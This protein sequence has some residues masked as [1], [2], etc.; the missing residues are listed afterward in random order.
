MKHA[1]ISTW[2]MSYN[3]LCLGHELLKKR[4]PLAEAIKKAINDVEDNP[5]YLSVGYG[6]L[7][8][9]EGEVEL[10]AAYMD[11]RSG[12]YGGIIGVKGLAN[13]INAAEALGR[14]QLNCLLGGAGAEKFARLEGFEFKN[15]LTEKA[16]KRWADQEEKSNDSGHIMI[17]NSHD[18]VSV[19]G[20]QDDQ[21]AVGVST[22]GLFLKAAGRVGDSP[23]PGAGLYADSAAGAAGATGT[24]EDIIRGCLSYETVR[25]MESGKTAQEACSAALENHIRRMDAKGL[26]LGPIALIALGA[27]GSFGAA[28]NLEQFA[29]VYADENSPPAIWLAFKSPAV[30]VKAGAELLEK[31]PF[32]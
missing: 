12:L 8:N 13:P 14:K 19:A 1:L 18:T 32:D 29:F 17:R 21:F 15:M 26:K 27:D 16:R 25:Q 22:S 20:R 6:G 31:Y 28:T 23:I 4:A 9:R 30:P 24:G 7:P 5:D 2:K 11:G 3:G 10:D